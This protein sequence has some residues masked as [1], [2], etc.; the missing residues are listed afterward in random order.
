MANKGNKR[1]ATS[2]LSPAL[3]KRIRYIVFT[4][5]IWYCFEFAIRVLVNITGAAIF[6]AMKPTVARRRAERILREEEENNSNKDSAIVLNHDEQ[7]IPALSDPLTQQ[8]QPQ[9]IMARLAAYFKF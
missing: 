1:K 8:Q 2:E 3:R 9:S 4:T 7:E 6:L 5:G